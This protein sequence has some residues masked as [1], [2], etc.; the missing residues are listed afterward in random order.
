MSIVISLGG[1]LVSQKK[2]NASFLSKFRKLVLSHLKN[3]KGKII[4]VVGGGAICRTYQHAAD[5][6][7]TIHKDDADWIGI[8]ATRLNAELVRSIFG[9]KAHSTVI[10]NPM[11]KVKTNKRIIVAAGFKPGRSTDFDA[12]MLAKHFKAKTVVNL[13]NI[14]YVYDK[15]PKKFK[16]AK[17]IE[18]ISWRN[19][20]KIVGSKWKPGLN[21]PFDPVA[22]KLASK[23]KL[24]VIIANG[25]NIKNIGNILKDRKFKGTVVS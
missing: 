17:K 14:N 24:K 1:S 18:S 4:L 7:S 19:F 2:I 13:S 15:D 21:M 11:K 9:K 16:S 22:T 6:I 8:M 12:V 20:K 5:K 23:L 10:I 3:N 25:Q